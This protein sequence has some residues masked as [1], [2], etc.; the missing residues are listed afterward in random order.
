MDKDVLIVVVNRNM[1]DNNVL[2]HVVLVLSIILMKKV[3]IFAFQIVQLEYNIYHQ[4][5]LLKR[6]VYNHVI[7]QV[8]I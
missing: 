4:V 5:I 2:K 7:C 8:D 1:M 6:C 3:D